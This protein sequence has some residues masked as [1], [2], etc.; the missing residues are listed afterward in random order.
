MF[1]YSAMAFLSS[2]T[3]NVPSSD[4][5]GNFLD[6]YKR[7]DFRKAW[8]SYTALGVSCMGSYKIPDRKSVV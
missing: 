4:K 2:G 5:G 1:K 8:E 6:V 7:Q 3:V